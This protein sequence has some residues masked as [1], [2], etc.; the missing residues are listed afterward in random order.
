MKKVQTH[1]I[2]IMLIVAAI[3]ISGASSGYTANKAPS[4]WAEYGV[5]QAVSIGLVPAGVQGRY[6]EPVTRAEF[7]ACAANVYEISSGNAI[8]YR[9]HFRDTDDV[10]VQKMGGLG[11]IRGKG[12][13]LFAPNDNLTRQ[14]AATILA[15]LLEVLNVPIVTKPP[16][17]SDVANTASWAREAVGQMQ[18]TGIMSGTGNDMFGPL[19]SYSIEQAIVT[20]YKVY[21]LALEVK[22]EEIADLTVPLGFF[23]VDESAVLKQLAAEV[24]ELVNAERVKAGLSS[25][26][27]T[28]LLNIAATVRASECELKYSHTRPDGRSF[29]TVLDDLNLSAWGVGENLDAAATSPGAVIQRWM[30]SPTHRDCIMKPDFEKMGVGIHRGADGRL[31]WAVLFIV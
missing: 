1:R 20:L 8:L 3:F 9:M 27:A 17:F 25:L 2:A 23:D 16:V 6:T 24:A 18:A 22:F 14:E 10:N 30:D 29:S 4:A 21:C 12:N 26:I 31:F 15:R 13:N 7:C 5:E 19:E 11:V 28:E